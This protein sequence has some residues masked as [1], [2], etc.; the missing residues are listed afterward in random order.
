M[1]LFERFYNLTLDSE[2]IGIG[3][4]LRS[5]CRLQRLER[6]KKITK[7]VNV[8]QFAHCKPNTI[9]LISLTAVNE[10]QADY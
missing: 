5:S 6:A 4:F 8:T 3:L 7:T 10:S 9:A 2:L 1:K